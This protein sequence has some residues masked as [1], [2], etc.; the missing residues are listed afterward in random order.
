MGWGEIRFSRAQPL[1]F[2]LRPSGSRHGP[3]S[4]SPVSPGGGWGV[5]RP[6]RS[7]ST[8]KP[9]GRRSLGPGPAPRM[10]HRVPSRTPE[11]LDL[12]DHSSIHPFISQVPNVP[13]QEAP[14]VSRTRHSPWPHGA[15]NLE[16][17]ERP[18]LRFHSHTGHVGLRAWSRLK[19][20]LGLELCLQADLGSNPSSAT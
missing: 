5:E 3:I 2:Y 20:G 10:A 14:E 19:Y 8:A 15:F 17:Q 7:S 11:R 13:G 16:A 6:D 18:T 1:I 4:T 9:Q 12:C